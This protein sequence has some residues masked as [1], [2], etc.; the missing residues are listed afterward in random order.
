MK[1]IVLVLL[2]FIDLWSVENIKIGVLA[3]R[4]KAETL[5]EWSETHQYL[6][7]YLPAYKIDFIPLTYPELNE[8]VKNATIDLVLT[9]PAHYAYLEKEYDVSRIATTMR[10][11]NHRWNDQF[12]GVIFSLKERKDIQ[13]LKDLDGLNIAVVDSE[14]LGGYAAQMAL[15]L[16][17]GYDKNDFNLKFSGMPHKNV[18]KMVLGKKADVGFVRTD[19][20]ESMAANGEINLSKIFI[21]NQQNY[22]NFNY[23]ISTKLYPEWPLARLKHASREMSNEITAMLMLHQKIHAKPFQGEYGWNAPLEYSEVHETLKSLQLPPYDQIDSFTFSDIYRKYTLVV[24]VL[25]ISITM[26]MIG[27]MIQI[28]L[29]KK[30]EF[31]N[32]KNEL[33]VTH[34]GDGVHILD[35]TLTIIQVSDT[36]CTMLGYTRDEMIGMNLN[37]WDNDVSYDELLKFLEQGESLNSYHLK[38]IHRRKDGTVYDADIRINTI[39]YRQKRWIYCSARDISTEM[40]KLSNAQLGSIVFENSSDAILIAD[41]NALIINVNRAFEIMSGYKQED[42]LNQSIDILKSGHHSNEYFRQ[43]WETIL[44][45]REW[46]GEIINRHKDG[47]VYTKWVSIQTIF[48]SDGKPYRHFAIFSDRSDEKQSAYQLWYQSNYDLLTGF[49][50]RHLF[51]ETLEKMVSTSLQQ[52]DPFALIHLDLDNFKEFNE[53]LGHEKGDLILIETSSRISSCI[54]IQDIVSRIGA[55]EFMIILPNTE[56]LPIIEMTIARL[57]DALS[58]P[59]NIHGHEYIVTCSI[60]ITIV[61]L[62]ANTAN[63]A[64]NNAEQAMNSA[65]KEGRNE[66]RFYTPSMQEEMISRTLMVQHMREAIIAK[67]FHLYYQPILDLRSNTIYKAE[68]LV[69]WIREDG[70]MINPAQF[71]PIAE[72][73]GLIHE[74]GFDVFTQGL[75]QVKHWR[76]HFSPN[77]QVSLNKSPVQFRSPKVGKEL[78][79]LMKN[80]DVAMDAIIVE[81]TEGILMDKTPVIQ[82]KLLEFEQSGLAIAL[83]DFGTGYSSLSYLKKFNI[84]YIKIDKIFVD[85]IVTDHHDQILCEAIIAMAHKLGI[86]VIAEGIETVEQR[87]YLNSIGCDYIQGYLISKPLPPKEFEYYFFN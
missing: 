7:D 17:H 1:K 72:E 39:N 27:L 19:V 12:G 83:D 2:L 11:I 34:S 86:E 79:A 23:L 80:L 13:T 63:S 25:A 73:T 82:N 10:F 67:E 60:G 45:G 4:S 74:I 15:L 56:S 22:P 81:I 29:R 47:T 38:S 33:F 75:E 71:I 61:P 84:D 28:R 44:N 37:Q 64:F 6:S 32:Q 69:R 66:Y 16:E 30:I 48:D 78:L 87:E 77:F 31:E 5:Q 3:F 76:E 20:L 65:K 41:R 26:I 53:T 8:A 68:A 40:A 18:V 52:G 58:R 51:M 43:I 49:I 21:I 46:R 14:S 54:K 85:N 57:F 24:W 42:A 35:E 9:N 50:N 70:M 62:D 59:Y 36:F 55:D